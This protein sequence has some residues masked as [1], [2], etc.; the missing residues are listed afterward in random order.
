MA[1]TLLDPTDSGGFVLGRIPLSR[2]NVLHITDLGTPFGGLERLLVHTR[3][4][5]ADRGHGFQLLTSEGGEDFQSVFSRWVSARHYLRTLS[6]IDRWQ[7]DVVHFHGPTRVV[8]PSP[9]LAARRRGLPTVVSLHTFGLYC[10]K[11][12]AIFEDGKP[13]SKGFN[14]RCWTYDCGTSYT[15][16]A[17]RAFH[18]LKWLKVGLHRKLIQSSADIFV[19]PSRQLLEATQRDFALSDEQISYIPHPARCETHVSGQAS[20]RQPGAF[21]FVGRL[22]P[23]KGLSVALHAIK[24]AL[25]DVPDLQFVVAGDG[26]ESDQMRLLARKLEVSSCVQFLGFLKPED[27][28]Q[29]YGRASAVVIPS[30]CMEGGNSLVGYEAMQAGTPV[31]ASDA[32]GLAGLVDDGE[33]GLLF[34]MGDPTALADAIIQIARHPKRARE[35]GLRGRAKLARNFSEELYMQRLESVYARAL[36]KK[37]GGARG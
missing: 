5:F 2:V 11:T 15:G 9:L 10:P 35:M 18:F 31:I 1:P 29:H 13:C 19:C 7:P 24:R 33:T 3:R 16:P 32:G 30:V 17:P 36:R 23:E 22:S 14:R 37:H 12:W 34:T 8:S 25:P 27:L 20:D 6:A 21:L 4:L 28:R 26:P